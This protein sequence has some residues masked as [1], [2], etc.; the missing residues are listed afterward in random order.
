VG[1][2]DGKRPPRRPRFRLVGNIEINFR[3]IEWG[4]MDWFDRDQDRDQWRA[5]MNTVI[6]F[7]V[8]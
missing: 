2:P 5:F 6:N 8:P 1:K 7:R 4:S 3:E